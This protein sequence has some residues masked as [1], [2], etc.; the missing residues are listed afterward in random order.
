MHCLYVNWYPYQQDNI[1]MGLHSRGQYC[2]DDE[3]D[4]DDDDDDDDDEEDD[5]DCR[6]KPYSSSV[7]LELID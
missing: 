3:E 2:S 4:D 6:S 5:D 1:G 7:S